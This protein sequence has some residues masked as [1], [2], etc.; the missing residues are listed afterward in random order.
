VRQIVVSSVGQVAGEVAEVNLGW[1]GSIG[2]QRKPA[3]GQSLLLHPDTQLVLWREAGRGR[4]GGRE[5]ERE[6]GGRQGARG[7]E[8]RKQ[9]A[10]TMTW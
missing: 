9:L 10:Q 4:A 3:L 5:R 8:G 1:R 7:R 6:G 2:T